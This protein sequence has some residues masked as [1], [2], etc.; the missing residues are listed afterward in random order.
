MLS[1]EEAEALRD[2]LA[3]A[4]REVDDLRQWRETEVAEQEERLRSARR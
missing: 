3:A 4:R 1:A 2:Q